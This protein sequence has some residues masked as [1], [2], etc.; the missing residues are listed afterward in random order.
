MK[1]CDHCKYSCDPAGFEDC[2]SKGLLFFKP[3][4]KETR[5]KERA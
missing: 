3:I 5:M 2:T 1:N 4:Q